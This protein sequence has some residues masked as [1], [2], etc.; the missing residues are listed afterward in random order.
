MLDVAGQLEGQRAARTAGAERGVGLGA[1]HQD[2]GDGGERE[3]V[4]DHG[5]LAEEAVVRGQRRLGPHLTALALEALEQ[6]RLLAADIGAGADAQ[7]DGAVLEQAVGPRHHQC[8]LEHG[9]GARILGT[10]VDESLARAHRE[11]ADDHALEQ[12]ERVALHDH[13]V[14]E[15]AGVT[16]VGVADDILG[17][18]RRIVHGAPLDAR[19]KTRTAA[20]AQAGGRDRIERRLRTERAGARKA[21][22]ATMGRVVVP[23]DGVDDAATNECPARLAREEGMLRRVADAQRVRPALE[24]TRLE[25]PRDIRGGDRAVTD[26]TGSGLHLDQGLEPMHAA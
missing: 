2:L 8:M 3:D 1:A 25:E 9:D 26:A 7:L 14:R 11:P 23:G 16:L 13:A 17:V 4:V 22:P 12:R 5:R 15:G 19:R 20:A 6:R 18:A 10:D 21:L 24:P